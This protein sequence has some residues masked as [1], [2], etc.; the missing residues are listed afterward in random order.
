MTWIV[1]GIVAM[2]GIFSDVEM[3]KEKTDAKIAHHEMKEAS[4]VKP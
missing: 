3:H 1:L 2:L 4:H